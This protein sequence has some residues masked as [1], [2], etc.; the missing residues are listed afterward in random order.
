MKITS[1]PLVF[2]DTTDSR[3]LE[4]YISS[5]HPTVQ[6]YDVND[7]T[8]TPDWSKTNLKLSADI[9]LDSEE[10]KPEKMKWYRQ[11]I[12]ETTETLLSN[13]DYT[14][15]ITVNGNMTQAV[16]TY[17]CRVEYQGLTAF[18][19]ITFTRT[20]TGLNGTNGKDGTSVRILGTATAVKTVSGTDYYTITYSNSAITAAELGDAYL[21]NGNLYVCAVKRDTD[22]YFINVGNI[23]GPA[24]ADG[25]DAKLITLNSNS[26]VFKVS[27]T[28][29]IA[30][31]T[32]TVTATAINTSVSSWTYSTDGGKTFSA[33]VPTGLSRSGNTVTLTGSTLSVN[34]VVIKASDGAC[35]D[36]MTIHK[37]IDGANGAKGDSASM[38]FL[39]NENISFAANANGQVSLTAVTT[40]VV[41]YNGIEKVMPTVGTPSGMPSGMT[42]SVDST[43]LAGSSKEVMLTISI[44]NNSTLGSIASNHGA[45]TIPITSP[46]ST[47]L[48]LSWSKINAGPKGEEGAGIRHIE[49]AYGVADSSSKRPGNEDWKENISDL[50]IAEGAYLWTRTTIDYTDDRDDT[51]T[52]TYI[53][54]GSKGDTGTSLEKIEIT[55]AVHSSATT[56][57]TSGWTSAIPVATADKQYL[58]TKTTFTLE[59]GTTSSAYS[60]AKQGRGIDHITEHYLATSASSNV[61]TSTSG[62]KET[63]QTVTSDNKYLWNYE[64]ISYTDGT[65]SSTN[66]TIIGVYGNTGATGATGPEGNGISSIE[67]WYLTTSASSGVT[68]STSGWKNTVQSLTAT[69]KYLWNYEIISYTNGSKVPTAP[70]IIGVY[71]DKG[72]K[73]DKGDTGAQGIQGI[74]GPKGDQGIQGQRGDDG[75]TSYF[76]IKYSANSNGN[77]MSDIP[78]TYIGTYVDY[79]SDDSDD[80]TKY[81]WSRF[82]GAQGAKGDQGIAGKNGENGLTSYLHIKYSNVA[83]PTTSSQ[84]NDV[85]GDY[86]GQY[87]DFESNDSTDPSK[88][89]WVKI[90]G[91]QGAQGIQGIQGERGEQGVQGKTGADGKTSYFHI[92]YSSNSNGNP[93]TETPSTYIGTYVDY[94][95]ADSSDYTKYTWSRFIG[96]QGEKGDQGIP[97]TN[98]ENGLTSYLHIAYATSSDGKTGFSTS[99]ASG[100]TYIGQ[101]TDHTQSDSTD[102]TKYK[103]TL[104]KGDKGDKGE[105]GVQG[106]KGNDG[107]QYYTWVKYADTPTSGMSDN[108]DGKVY[109]GL[110]Y[111]KTTATESTTYSDYMWSLIKGETGAVGP[112]GNDGQTYYTWIKYADSASGSNMSDSPNGK[113]YI[114]LAY[115]KTTSTES[116][117]ASDYTWSL[118]K[119]DK[120]DKGD[121]GDDGVGIASTTVTYGVSDSSST[122]PSSWQNTIPTVADGKYLW[123]RTIIDYTDTAR[124]D[125]V[126]YTYAKQGTKGE[127][128]SA[129]SSVTVTSIQ[130]QEGSSA[131]TAPTGTWSNSVVSV[132]D[133]K[134]LWTKIVFSDGKTS[135]GVAK[136]GSSGRGVSS[137]AEEYYQSTSATAQSGGSWSTTVPTWAD[138]KY[139]W[140]RSVITYTDS[141]TYTT[142]PVCV[143]G[144]KGATGG[145]GST[146][147]T[148]VGVSSVDVWYYQSTSSTS[149]TGGSW[150]TTAPTWADGKYV[151]TKTITTYTNSTT[152][153]TAAVC[154][155]GQKGA[156]GVG[157]KSVTE[158]YLAT[159]SSSGVTS[160]TSGWTTDIQTITSDKKYLWNYEVI[161]YTDNT[162]SSTAPV[163][164]GAFGNTGG[165]GAAGK[166]IKSV[167][168]YYLASASAS[169]VTTSTTG[170]TTTMQTLTATNKYLWNY[171]LLTYTDN[172][173][174]TISPVIIGVY[175]DKGDKGNTGDRG[176]GI[177][178]VTVTYGTSTAATTQPTSWQSTLPT[179]AEGSYL[180]TRTVT[181]YTDTSIEDT[182]TLTYAKQGAK[183]STGTAGTSVTVS[184]IQ[185]QAGTSATTAPTGT[186]SDTVVTVSA[187]SYLWTKTTFSD[188][189]IAYGVAR[190]GSDGAKGATGSAGAD[191]YTV[192]LTNESHVFAG[193]TANALASTATTQVLAYKGT[194][195]QTVTIVSVNGVTAATALT[196]TGIAGLSFA[197]SS[198]SG[199]TPTITFTCTTA[200]VSQSGSIPIVL[201]VGGVSI[202]KMFTYSIAFKGSTGATG[203][204]GSAGAA[205]TAYWLITDASVVQKSNS[206]TVV[207]T[208]STLTFTGKSKT[209]TGAPADYACRWIIAYSTD[210]SAYTNSYTSSANEASKTFAVDSSYKSVRVRM[211]LA[212]GTSTLLDE[213]IIPVVSDGAIGAPGMDAVTFQIYSSSGYALSTNTPS[214]TLQTF[215]YVG[216]VAITAGATYQWYKYSASGWTTISGATN[217]YLAISRDDVAFSQSYMCKMTFNSVEYTS[218][219]TID[220]KNDNNKVFTTKPSNYAAG[221]IWIVG[222]D[223]SPSGVEIGTLLKAQYT[224]AS[225][226]DADWIKATKY[227]EQLKDL[228]DNLTQ[229][230]QYFSFDSTQ[231]VK[232]TA[233]DSN[234]VES[235]YSTTISNDEWAINYGSEAVTYVDETKMHIK[236]AEIESPLTITGKYS[237]STMLQAPIMNIGNFS[238]VIESNGSLSVVVKS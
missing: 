45:I 50:T 15:E 209:G 20:D 35:A 193:D 173:T 123:T 114:G 6:L 90:K 176:A 148:G 138:G 25:A 98:G 153:E 191:A 17:I 112:K 198:L 119:G 8:Y 238:L 56:P 115:N 197:C 107:Q 205:A 68:T 158:Y 92:K 218:V 65:S 79:T 185:Y 150:S 76:H 13:G 175:G 189:K 120:G 133:G 23:Q 143:T 124:A 7:K 203:G 39:T 147:A 128:G 139:I 33:T 30:P 3:K 220:D 141:T 19:K 235:K 18:S 55:Y 116:T 97:G 102:A 37:V 83:N 53:K 151:W 211:Y 190:Q 140:T 100:K 49:V 4:V 9:F 34:S 101:Y 95:E 14:E 1:Q 178:S 219:V 69:N 169:G 24:G 177:N 42:I 41:A 89:T 224:N 210:G 29:T 99:D 182:V 201:S 221:D 38:A 54:Q 225:Y 62:W 10:I 130:Y 144:Q 118:F 96:A 59:D 160:S 156:T 228:Q 51:V 199:T 106:P 196:A 236:E 192:L 217:A 122:Q 188:G 136:Q 117:T 27:N 223:Y 181:D 186:W 80:Y 227:D 163:I 81:T 2:L 164:I 208:P 233:K 134:Y 167:T 16:V 180:W 206:G 166:G 229:Y 179:V 58:W 137:I 21:Y 213:Q 222:S 87:T 48:K 232:I 109:I 36:T 104:I 204:T 226:A 73:G 93:M 216:D 154:I 105:Q 168:E 60:V 171:E 82:V 129:G 231:G 40:N 84:I 200:F 126:S 67:E 195:A 91:E 234:G 44:A 74:Q 162:T 142:T 113:S 110:A 184:S 11:Y 127:T 86:I 31:A 63:I 12:N 202:T 94:T 194:T 165:T 70:V 131:T 57:P 77:P 214:V 237:G 72:D 78:S 132:A 174:A 46:V 47:N 187:G 172:S 145:T 88:Y 161:T 183:G 152:D 64:T 22:D 157:V 61:T 170:W 135:Y 85:G 230:N 149:L 212:G 121:Q 75:R 159:A 26:Q 108:P 32:I 111:N 5:N 125:T 28:G 215:A 155:T 103:W 52:Y 43:S 207:L 71:G 146:G 66:P